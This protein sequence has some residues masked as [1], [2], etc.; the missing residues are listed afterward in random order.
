[1][2]AKQA[3]TAEDV[4]A[5]SPG[6]RLN[7]RMKAII[8]TGLLP[9]LSPSASTVLHYAAAYGDFAACTVFMGA[10]TV[11]GS[12]F[13]G[14]RNRSSAKVGITELL[15][16]GFLA[17]VKAATH[18]RAAVY[19]L[20]LDKVRIAAAQARVAAVGA[21]RRKSAEQRAAESAAKKAAARKGAHGSAPRGLTG[22][23]PGGSWVS[24]EGAHGSAPNHSSNVPSSL[25]ERYASSRSTRR[26]RGQEAD[27]HE[28]RLK[29]AAVKRRATA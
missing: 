25:K 10:K 18:R 17:I 22:Q 21:K 26:S 2:S 29:A 12:A 27:E 8:S 28:Q 3:R 19:R 1:M 13:N 6:L 9:S 23:P 14:S 20:T 15:E 11:A 4:H 5:E 24:P 16:V 7:R